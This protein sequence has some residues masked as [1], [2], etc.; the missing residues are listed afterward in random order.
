M[1][2]PQKVLWH[3]D[4]APRRNS[5]NSPPS[6]IFSGDTSYASETNSVLQQIIEQVPY[7]AYAAFTAFLAL[8]GL[9]LPIPEEAP[10]VLAGVL[11]ANGTL[12]YPLLAYFSCLL[13]SLMGD[14]IMY[15]IGRHFGHGFLLSHPKIAKFV[16]P[17]K[18]EEF[19]HI[20]N[21]HG[22]KALLLTRFLIGVRGPVYFAAGAARVPYLRFLCWDLVAATM[23][24]SVVFGLAYKYGE[25]VSTWIR[26]AQYGLTAVALVVLLAAAGFILYKL[27][28]RK[29][30]AALERLSEQ[31]EAEEAAEKAA[32]ELAEQIVTE[33]EESEAVSKEISA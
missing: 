13:G 9:G 18:E 21:R 1:Q 5:P 19:E 11:S 6:S 15:G 20:V 10:L 8:T 30:S 3:R 12:E 27:Q 16:D 2:G 14:S 22:F 28:N 31:T 29:V 32:S 17:K 25:H 26:E 7:L 23:V 4:C 33:Q 24:V